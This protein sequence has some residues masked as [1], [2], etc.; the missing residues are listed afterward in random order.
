MKKKIIPLVFVVLVAG[1]L[2]KLRPG[3]PFRYAGTIEATET[4]LSARIPGVIERYGAREGDPVKKGQ[5]LAALDCADLRLAAGIAADDFRRAEELYSGGSVSKENYDRLKYRRDDSAL[6]VDWCSIKSPV[7]GRLLY[8]YREKGE[9]VAPGTK[10]ATVA[11]LS[12]VWAY[13]YVPHDLLA[14]LKPGMELKGY[15]PE[16]G[17][18]EFPG[19]ISVIHSEAEFTPKNVQTRKERTRLVFAVKV[20]F[21]NPGETLKP[22]MTIEIRLPE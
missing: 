22:G 20:S 1:V 5:V 18:K 2:F 4:D 11:D 21:P 6:R 16:A 13:I 19:R 3:E 15:L 7:D 8:A 10:L 17:D 9:L 14:A 12:E